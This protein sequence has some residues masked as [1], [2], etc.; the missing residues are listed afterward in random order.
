M[1]TV[2][3]SLVTYDVTG[4]SPEACEHCLA[5]VKSELIRVPGVVGVDVNT[6]EARVSILTDGPV[7]DALIRAAMDA[8]GCAVVT[9]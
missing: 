4:L 5:S 1:I 7:D 2:A 3:Y 9:P 6:E 8:A